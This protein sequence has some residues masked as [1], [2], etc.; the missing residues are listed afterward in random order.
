M[1][2][3]N[4]TRPGAGEKHRQDLNSGHLTL[5]PEL[6]PLGYPALSSCLVHLKLYT[7]GD[8]ITYCL[9]LTSVHVS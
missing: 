3:I 9:S 2:G 6:F 4:H 8:S 1:E 7:R 5:G